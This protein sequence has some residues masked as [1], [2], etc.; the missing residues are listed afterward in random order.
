[1][2]VGLTGGIAA[3][4]STVASRLRELGAA[5]IDYD[6]LAQQVVAPGSP[7]IE[8]IVH[9]FGHEAIDDQGRLRRSWLAT[10]VFGS[11]QHADLRERLNNIVHPLVY[12]RAKTLEDDVTTQTGSADGVTSTLIVHDV[13]L[14]TEVID[15][16]PFSFAHIISVEAPEHLRIE[17]MM[18]L[19]H[20]SYDDA[21]ARIAS[22]ASAEE[23]L[24]IADIVIDSAV[25]I[26]HMFET[27]DTIYEALQNG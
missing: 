26:E 6:A 5:V 11:G 25:S 19:R 7:G 4:K 15:S 8:Q 1:M 17:R 22:Q 21:T 3:G 27:V 20:M 23:R 14:L 10:S 16:I 13:P 2:R 24:K 9:V 18:K 12:E